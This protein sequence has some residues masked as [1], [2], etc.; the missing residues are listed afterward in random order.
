MVEYY[1]QGHITPIRPF[2]VFGADAVQ[3]AFK[4]MQQGQ[5]IG[6]V[7]VSSL[8]DAKISAAQHTTPG[9]KLHSQFEDSASYLLV[10]GLGGLGQAVALWMVERGARDFIFLS[11]NAG[12]GSGD[13][14]FIQ[15]L[16][17]QGCRVHLV[18]GDVSHYADVER[19]FSSANFPVKGVM[20]MSMVLRD[21]AFADM[22]FQDWTVPMLPKI[23]G[24][25]NL[26]N[27]SVRNRH[28][29]DFFV[30][31]SSLYGTVG[32]PGQANYNAANTFLD[33]F[34]SFRAGLGLAASTIDIGPVEDVGYVAQ[35]RQLLEKAKS[36]AAYT[37]REAELLRS[38]ELAVLL[39]P[40]GR[41]HDG[42]PSLIGVNNFVLGLC[43]PSGGSGRTIWRSDRRM[44]AYH[45]AA[46][47]TTESSSAAG[48]DLLSFLTSAREDPALLRAPEQREFLAIEIGKK[49]CDLLAR[50]ESD[51]DIARPMSDL[52]MDSL[53][54]IEMRSWWRKVFKVDITVLEL[55][56]LVT[57]QALGNHAADKLLASFAGG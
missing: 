11:R 52:G 13:T 49:M 24:T 32:L 31:F 28:N 30:L 25:W 42:P 9:R 3:D 20:Q 46:Q 15:E 35:N 6:K 16:V 21:K 4:Y 23:Q 57:L 7:I 2:E 39:R 56:G 53:V 19:A 34:A 29:L 8:G 27:A 1:R 55:L 5:H 51:L 44:A 41:E 12:S 48:G 38:L 47:S 22:S 54:A 33:A 43:A 18:R 17:S 45:N 14:R 50:P 10:G 36:T 26:H 37:V 40:V